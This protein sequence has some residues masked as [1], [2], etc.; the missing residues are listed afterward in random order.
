MSKGD[1]NMSLI[2]YL[3]RAP[4]YKNTTAKEIILIESY[5]SW[6]HENEIKSKYSCDTFE[7]WCSHSENEL[8]SKDTINY[9]KPFWTTKPMYMEMIGDVE[10][11]SIFEQL[12]R[13]VKANPIF[14]WFYNN[15]MEQNFDREYHEVT[16]NQLEDFLEICKKVKE[17]CITLVKENQHDITAMNEYIVN[18][19]IAKELLPTYDNAQSYFGPNNYESFYAYQVVNAI[20]VV[21]NILANTDFEKQIIYLN[22]TSV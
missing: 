17:D 15:V 3:T 1:D 7:K 21:S 12:A 14:N 9:Y 22:F 10:C 19:D 18:E 11:R 4:K 5:L 20:E 6:Q 8:P 16:K 2:M 13:F